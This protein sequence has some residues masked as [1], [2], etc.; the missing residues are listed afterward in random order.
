MRFQQDL[1]KA[2]KQWRQEGDRLIVCMD[3]NKDIYKKSIGKTLMDRDGLNMVE[4]V[5]EF[6]GKKIG[7]TFFQGSKPINGIWTTA[8]IIVTHAWV[9]P[10]GYGVGDHHLF[11]M[12]LQEA[13]LIGEAPF[14]VQQFTSRRLNT[15]VSRGAT[16]NYLACLE[17][18]LA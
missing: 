6:T 15:K 1:V 18:S 2:L 8:D 3:A 13:S 14:R 10:A 17:A 4:E 9:M 11:V 12:D 7:P 5:G 16:R